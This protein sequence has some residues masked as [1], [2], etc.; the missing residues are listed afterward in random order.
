LGWQRYLLYPS[1]GLDFLLGIHFNV[2]VYVTQSCCLQDVVEE[3]PAA[4]EIFAQASDVLG[5]DLLKVCTEGE[6][7]TIPVQS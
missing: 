7:H 1:A 4:K 3:V 6:P 5:Y 2:I